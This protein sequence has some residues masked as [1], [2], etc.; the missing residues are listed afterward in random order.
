MLAAL[1]LQ[2]Q[3]ATQTTQVL[4]L[5][6]CMALTTNASMRQKASILCWKNGNASNSNRVWDSFD[7]TEQEIYFHFRN[8]M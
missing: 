4:V 7:R 5:V 2:A 3:L 6:E 8:Y 1:E